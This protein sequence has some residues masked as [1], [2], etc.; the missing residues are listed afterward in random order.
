M[1]I[2]GNINK[3]MKNNKIYFRSK[4]DSEDNESRTIKGVAVVFNKWSNDLGGYIERIMPGA[5]TQELI[6][7]SD[8]I[9]N[10][11]HNSQD[12][13]MARCK[14]GKGTL[15]L[16]LKEDGLYFSFEA[17]ETDKGDELLYHVRKGNID[18]CS[19]AFTLSREK[20]AEKWYKDKDGKL[21]RDI[22]HIDG[23]YDI[24]LVSHAAYSDTYCYSQRAKE[25]IDAST[26]ISNKYDAILDELKQF[27]I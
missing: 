10:R 14:N 24:S 16:E 3:G 5:I 26:E 4:L 21:C 15:N 18:E 6:D 25:M 11:E 8:V 2:Y 7:K 17:P 22:N 20:D 9:A 13:M 27:I 19:F 23:L 12:Y 1:A